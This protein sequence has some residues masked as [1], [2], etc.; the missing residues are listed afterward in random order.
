MLIFFCY[1]LKVIV[2][3]FYRN[4]FF[5]PLS[6]S[7]NLKKKI[8]R[9]NG[10][11]ILN[12]FRATNKKKKKK[13]KNASQEYFLVPYF[14][15]WIHFNKAFL[16]FFSNMNNKKATKAKN[17]KKKRTE[18]KSSCNFIFSV[19]SWLYYSTLE[20]HLSIQ[21]VASAMWWGYW[22]TSSRWLISHFIVVFAMK[23]LKNC[24]RRIF[25]LYFL[26]FIWQI[27]SWQIK[28]K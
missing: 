7:H 11:L 28:K 23:F 19:A 12:D 14:Y 26:Y 22:K 17:K 18:P 2:C 4:T 5:K 25:F 21:R 1:R 9:W 6:V 15:V 13:K 27:E 3:D 8:S 16:F 20:L 24:C 10:L